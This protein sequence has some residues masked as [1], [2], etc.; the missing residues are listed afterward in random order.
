MLNLNASKYRQLAYSFD[1]LMNRFTAKGGITYSLIY[2]TEEAI[3]QMSLLGCILPFLKLG[4]DILL[5]LFLFVKD[6]STCAHYVTS[7]AEK[8]VL[9]PLL[10]LLKIT[11]GFYGLRLAKCTIPCHF[12]QAIQ[13]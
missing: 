8:R 10:I 1:L 6:F 2:Q 11:G 4:V 7:F 12:R 9:P 5:R 3:H 13:L